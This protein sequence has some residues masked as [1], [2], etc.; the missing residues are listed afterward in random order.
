MQR[1][2]ELKHIGPKALVRALLEE[3]IDRLEDKLQRAASEATSV[4]VVFDVNGS[5][6]LYRTALTC[7]VP[8]RT[9]AAHEEARNAGT[10]IRAAFSE[11]ERQLEKQKAIVR[12]EHELRRSKRT[13]RSRI[14]L[15][16]V[17]AGLLLGAVRAFAEERAALPAVPS[18]KALEAMRLLDSND[19]YQRELGFL[20]L[21]ALREISTVDTIAA[22]LTSR[23]PETRAY[24]LRAMAAIQ[25]NAAVPLLL[26]TLKTDKDSHV[27]RAALLGLEPLQETDPAVL[28]AFIKALRDPKTDVRI[29]AV[30][31][32]SRIDSPL[33][34]EAIRTRNK[35]EQRRD[36]RRVLAMAMQ[37]LK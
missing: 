1:I 28:P 6:K 34:R 37:R 9:I 13:N 25:G 26:R 23:N 24:S 16:W 35:R 27:R 15:S 5:H 33:A 20:R 11:I 3:L 31:I 4:H 18:P 21:E 36:V 14:L 7:H 30:D 8:G 22:H 32:V 29:T 19:A 10:S 12:H 17:G 2:I